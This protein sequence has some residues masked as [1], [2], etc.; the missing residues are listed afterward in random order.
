MPTDPANISPSCVLPTYLCAV[1]AYDT[2]LFSIAAWSTLQLSWTL[3]LLGTQLWQVARQM[4][5]FEVSNLGRYGYMGGRGSTSLASQMGHQHQHLQFNDSDGSSDGVGHAHAHGHN[6]KH[7][8]GGCGTGFIM[9]LTGLD[10][11]TKGK[12]A[13]GLARAGKATNPF[14]MGILSNCKDF[15]TSGKE[16]GVE[17][18]R[19]YS[20]PQEGFQEAKL[21]RMKEDE[22]DVR[23]SS[24]RRKKGLFM[25]LSLGLGRGSRQGYEPVNQV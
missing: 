24:D 20:V 23:N 14:D 2:F 17:Y 9:Q 16:L 5:T 12:A 11:F 3:V 22:D 7:K 1:T 6:H 10:M 15:W 8:F 21:K 13:D 4:T 25:G 18:D 19:L